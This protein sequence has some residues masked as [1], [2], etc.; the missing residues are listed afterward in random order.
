[1]S[2]KGDKKP[3]HDNPIIDI[4]DIYS[5]YLNFSDDKQKGKSNV[6][7]V[8]RFEMIQ[9]YFSVLESVLVNIEKCFLNLYLSS[10]SGSKITSRIVSIITEFLS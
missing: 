2:K 6:N 10:E 9:K 5:R 8:N 3:Q 7:D 4:I 1:M